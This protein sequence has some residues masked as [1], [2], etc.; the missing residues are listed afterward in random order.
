MP[1]AELLDAG[2][3]D[4]GVELRVKLHAQE[5]AARLDAAQH[6]EAVRRRATTP[7]VGAGAKPARASSLQDRARP[8]ASYHCG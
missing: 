4:L 1:A 8:G 7:T 2:L 5:P 6:R 3:D